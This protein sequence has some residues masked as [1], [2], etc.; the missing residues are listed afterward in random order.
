MS[1]K[2]TEKEIVRYYIDIADA[3]QTKIIPYNFPAFSGV[4]LT[5]GMIREMRKKADIVGIKF[6]SNDLFQLERMRQEDPELVIFNGFDEIFLAGLAMG[7]DGAVGSTFNVMADKFVGIRRAF[8]SGEI[9]VAKRVQAEA[10]AVITALQ[11]SGCLLNAEK[12]LLELE[13]LEVGEARK[14]FMP[15]TKEAKNSLKRVYQEYLK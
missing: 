5:P 15:L 4:T 1:Y 12:Y 13:G 3:V 9:S 6:T 11:E 8:M 2:F 14:P 7:A 10:N